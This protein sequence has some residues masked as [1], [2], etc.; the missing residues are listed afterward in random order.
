[1]VD[2]ATNGNYLVA[3]LTNAPALV[4]NGLFTVMLDFGAS[5]FNGSARWL[6]IGVRTN[7]STGK[8]PII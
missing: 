7:G 6:E 3:P 4:S 2:A 8:K 1:L 5:V